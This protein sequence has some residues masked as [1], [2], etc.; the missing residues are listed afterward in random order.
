MLVSSSSTCLTTYSSS[1]PRHV[2]RLGIEHPA[3]LGNQCKRAAAISRYIHA[4]DVLN[5]RTIDLS[6]T[7]SANPRLE[8]LTICFHSLGHV[9]TS[10]LPDD[11]GL[12]EE[13]NVGIIPSPTVLRFPALLGLVICMGI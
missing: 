5:T 12:S 13:G 3:E 7:P 9:C 8:W 2:L 1:I 6:Q 4:N 10:V 11:L